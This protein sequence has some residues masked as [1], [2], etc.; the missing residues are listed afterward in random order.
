MSSGSCPELVCVWEE[1]EVLG[2]WGVEVS[3]SPI[4]LKL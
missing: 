2:M 4:P 3:V 1:M